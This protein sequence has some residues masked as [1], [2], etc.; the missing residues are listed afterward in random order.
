[1]NAM[2]ELHLKRG[3]QTRRVIHTFDIFDTLIARRCIDAHQVFFEVEAR[4]GVTG[5]A[6][7]RKEAER[8]VYHREYNFA[9]IYAGVRELLNMDDEATECLMQLEVQV[10]LEN[11]I[12]ITSMM[13]N[14]RQEAVL[15]T[16]M[17]LPVPVI[18]ELLSR[19]G[20]QREHPILISSHGKSSG[21]IWRY[22]SEQ[23]I[24]C[25][26]HGDNEHS[27]VFNAR[28]F[29]MRARMATATCL[30]EFESFLRERGAEHAAGVLRAARLQVDT[31]GVPEWMRR[32][33]FNL[34]LPFLLVSML[35]LLSE[36][37]ERQIRKV[38]FASRDGRHLH[39]AFLALRDHFEDLMSVDAEYWFTSR[40]AR[41][42]G[43]NDYVHYCQSTFS[44]S[45]AMVDLCG[46]GASITKLLGDLG[47]QDEPV[48]VYLAQKVSDRNYSDRMA[49]GYG[50]GS[51]DNLIPVRHAFDTAR[52]I[53]NALIEQLNYVPE[54]MIRD[55]MMTPSGPLPVR[56]E[57]DFEGEAL[58]LVGQ[59]NNLLTGFFAQL[60]KEMTPV[61]LDELVGSVPAIYEWMLLHVHSLSRDLEI[62][63]HTLGIDDVSNENFTQNDLFR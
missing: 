50:L 5:F 26:H 48:L 55:V 40:V 27:D 58:R 39:A 51:S 18:R 6:E 9:D 20:V 49:Q 19:A 47:M 42:R 35:D 38:L 10:E 23:G 56:D 25:I 37:R 13:K 36:L 21:S 32:L 41:T 62:L 24:Q 34:N 16:D 44:E 57:V 7:V 61:A 52:F 33:Q 63:R 11:V 45:M 8:N 30:T 14:L 43:S 3:V 53:N 22:F 2:S 15:I 54:G 1:M 12:P 46:T 59:Q 4:S 17:Y 28:T 29:G 31:D 60:S